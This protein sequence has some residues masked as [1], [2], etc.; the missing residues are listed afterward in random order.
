MKAEYYNLMIT[1]ENEVPKC[2]NSEGHK[3]E[4][5]KCPSNNRSGWHEDKCINCGITIGYDTSD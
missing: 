5:V 4:N 2:T 3:W 1:S